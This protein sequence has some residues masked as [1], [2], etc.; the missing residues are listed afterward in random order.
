MIDP[1]LAGKVAL[2]TGA[3]HGIGEAIARSLASQSV[4]VFLHYFR[5]SSASSAADNYQLGQSQKA[6]AI[7]EDLKQKGVKAACLELNLES[8]QSAIELFR[9]ASTALGPIDILVNNAASWTA[10]TFLPEQTND[11]IGRKLKGIDSQSFDLHFKV[12]TRA[13]AL[14]MAELAKQAATQGRSWGRIINISTGGAY[15]FPEEVSYG[16]A[17]FALE[18]YGRSAAKELGR[19][20]ITV[21][22]VAP[23]ATQTGW[24]SASFEE[25]IARETPLGRVGRPEDIADVVV[26][27]CSEQAR[28]V[29]GQLIHV[30]GAAVV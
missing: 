24:I 28:F 23:G 4:N 17:K 19:F 20:G 18:S 11:R 14:L 30:G 25:S 3:N 7:V 1:Q 29:S 12:I 2:I 6:D 15:C 8:E 5:Q 16:A 22:T 26:F 9:A 27:L 13:S 10:D 21:N